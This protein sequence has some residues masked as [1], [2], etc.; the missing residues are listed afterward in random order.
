MVMPR[1]GNKRRMDYTEGDWI[2]GEEMGD[3]ICMYEYPAYFTPAEYLSI[4]KL[5]KGGELGI[6]GFGVWRGVFL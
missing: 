1:L 2:K 3:W 4:W 5:G 6:V